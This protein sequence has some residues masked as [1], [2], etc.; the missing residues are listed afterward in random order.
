MR[1][2]IRADASV[3]IGTGHV[4]RC[5]TLAA[6][7]ARRGAAVAF[8]AAELPEALERM[9]RGEGYAVLR[10]GESPKSQED[11]ARRTAQALERFG[12]PDWLV[13][14]H[15][16]LD[17]RWESA[18]REAAGRIFVI[19]DLAD[20]AHDCDALLDPNYCRG[21]EGRYH[22]L[23]PPDCKLMLGPRFLLLRP[24]FAEARK[25]AR[26]RPERAVR[27]VLV[28]FGGSDPTNETEKALLAIARLKLPAEIHIDVVAGAA[29]PQCGRIESLCADFGFE[30]T[31]QAADL[32]RRMAE[33]DFSLGAAG[34]AM[35][36]RCYLGLPAAVTVVA[37]NQRQTAEDAAAY[38]A[39]WSLGSHDDVGAENYADILDR[40]LASP[41][42]LREMSLRAFRLTDPASGA[43]GEHPAVRT[44]LGE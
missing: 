17:R 40:A 35:W 9:L 25:T 12:K 3:D 26:P 39:V 22:G 30:F 14:D 24:E 28:F 15:Y 13:V 42:A 18:M 4:M 38:G 5:K 34:G 33:A 27:R 19:D 43:E 44:I 7:L 2:A 16:R 11:D 41:S 29:N 31:C 20:R 36:E 37:E 32:A 21:C 23:V 8:V 6:R 1:V 10:I